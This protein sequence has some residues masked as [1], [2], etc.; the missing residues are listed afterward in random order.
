[1]TIIAHEVTWSDVANGRYGPAPERA[2]PTT[3]PDG[4]ATLCDVVRTFVLLDVDL[5][6]AP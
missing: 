2:R 1:M 4:A 5:L 6:V 3:P